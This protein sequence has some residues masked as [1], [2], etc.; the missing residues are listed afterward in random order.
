MVVQTKAKFHVATK[1]FKRYL[2]N[3]A[4]YC[5][6]RKRRRSVSCTKKVSLYA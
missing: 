2:N 4:G 1:P 5:E 6:C 3:F